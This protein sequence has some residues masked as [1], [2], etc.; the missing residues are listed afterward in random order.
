MTKK[1]KNIIKSFTV[2]SFPKSRIA[3]LKKIVKIEN[4]E[5][6]DEGIIIWF[7]SPNS[8]TGEDMA[9]FHVHG[10]RAV[11]QSILDNIKIEGCKDLLNQVNLP[12]EHF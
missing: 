10:S 9:E 12:K 4:K 2:G 8:Y 6:I 5:L 1:P 3:T 11:I 7:P